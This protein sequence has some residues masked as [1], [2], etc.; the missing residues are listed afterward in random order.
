MVNLPEDIRPEWATVFPA[1]FNVIRRFQSLATTRNRK[2]AVLTIRVLV[3]EHGNPVTW[4]EPE[5]T[6]LEPMSNGEIPNILS[7]LS[8]GSNDHS[9]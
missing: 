4:G 3:D 1:W 2:F 8:G 9:A 7:M 5:C 6:R